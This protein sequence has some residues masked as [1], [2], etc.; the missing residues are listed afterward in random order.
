MFNFF[1]SS[2]PIDGK[3]YIDGKDFFHIKN[4]L[5][6]KEG[7]EILVSDGVS[8]NLCVIE[9]FFDDK[10][11]ARITEPDFMSTNLPIEIVLF[12]AL[13]KSDKLELIIQKAVELGANKIVPVQTARCVVKIEEKK[14]ADKTARWQAIAESAGKQSKRCLI[15]TV[16]SPLSFKQA[17]ELFDDLDLVILPYENHLGMQS[18]LESLS[19]IKKGMKV[20][21]FIGP[22]GGFEQSE[23]D[24]AQQKGAKTIS[25]GKRILRAETAAITTLSMLM[26]F[27]EMKL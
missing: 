23:V 14:K 25:L 10:V 9:S 5:R 6:M 26:L 1:V 21:V 19:L 4:V 12:Q 16:L 15:P 17:L 18:T 8:G 22:E 20:G 2:K 7:D 27:A 11:T 24:L 13:P 3:Y